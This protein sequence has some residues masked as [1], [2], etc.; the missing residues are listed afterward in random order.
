MLKLI[1]NADDFGLSES[2]N[3]S[4]AI[5]LTEGILTSKSLMASGRVFSQAVALVSDTPHSRLLSAFTSLSLKNAPLLSLREFHLFLQP[6]AAF[7]KAQ[8]VL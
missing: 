8:P 7:V 6:V 2:V 3:E 5:A 4:I 1:V